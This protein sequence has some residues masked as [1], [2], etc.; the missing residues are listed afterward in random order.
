MIFLPNFFDKYTAFLR[1]AVE[2]LIHKRG[3]CIKYAQMLKK[4]N[5]S[6]AIFYKDETE[7]INIEGELLRITN[8]ISKPYSIILNVSGNY[9]INKKLFYIL[10]LKILSGSSWLKFS[11]IN[12]KVVLKT[13]YCNA[14][15]F[16]I[17]RALRGYYFFETSSHNLILVFSA[18]KTEKAVMNTNKD[19]LN[20][21]NPYSLINL[22]LQ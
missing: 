22:F 13:N 10:I 14:E 2:N 11:T 17:I 19:W 8:I 5:L 15:I 7:P 16:K 12:G 4:I 1:L 20:L 6:E 21:A 9:L 18:E 3:F